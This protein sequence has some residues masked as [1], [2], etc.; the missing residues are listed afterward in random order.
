[1]RLLCAALGALTLLPSC[2]L[3]VTAPVAE[4]HPPVQWTK[5]APQTPLLVFSHGYHTGLCLPAYSVREHLPE[6][7]EG[8]T[9]EWLEFGWGD[10]GFYRSE[11]TTPQL[12]FS[13]LC[14][15]TPGVVHVVTLNDPIHEN[16][17]HMPMEIFAINATEVEQLSLFLSQSFK[18]ELNGQLIPRG[19]GRYGNST[20]YR[21]KNSYYFPRSCNAWTAQALQAAEIDVFAVTAPGLMRELKK[22]PAKKKSAGSI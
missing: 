17:Q 6:L 18:R 19:P 16:Y 15:P 1:M 13:A 8:L 11:K 10:E 7:C 3:L 21:A 14:Y 12:V 20:F 2:S 5:S 9:D 4:P 22:K